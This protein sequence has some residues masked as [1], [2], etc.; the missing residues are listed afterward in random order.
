MSGNGECV[1]LFISCILAGFLA[2]FLFDV[3]RALRIGFRLKKAVPVMDV[4]FWVS[5]V[6]VCYKI[7]FVVGEGQLRGFCFL[8][9]AGGMAVYLLSFSKV[10]CG[11]MVVSTRALNGIIMWVLNPIKALFCA[12]PETFA[13][14]VQNLQ[15]NVKNFGKK[16]LEKNEK[17]V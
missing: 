1:A 6:V 15:K 14:I 9:I 12:I 2:G 3:F 17:I 11:W 4:L 5:V 13:E 16:T 8:G 7:I 10:L